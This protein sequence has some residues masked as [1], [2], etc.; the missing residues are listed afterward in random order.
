MQRPAGW[1]RSHHTTAHGP[2]CCP[3]AI[4]LRAL[5]ASTHATSPKCLPPKLG[6]PRPPR[7]PPCPHCSWPP[8]LV[9]HPLRRY[10][11]ET[12]HPW[13][14][15]FRLAGRCAIND[16]SGGDRVLDFKPP[17][18][19]RCL[20]RCAIAEEGQSGQPA[21][22]GVGANNGTD[23]SAW[24]V[25]ATLS[26]GPETGTCK[27]YDQYVQNDAKAF[28]WLQEVR[29]GGHLGPRARGAAHGGAAGAGGA[30]LR[31]LVTGG[32]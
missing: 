25:L 30:D 12:P 7:S 32:V 15:Y 21:F 10:P 11:S 2:G 9:P 22:V 1:C 8:P 4:C 18:Q 5:F 3:P 13:G 27:G 29:G 23:P 16:A 14:R 6:A 17:R 19:R 24:A 28:D 20:S 31:S 26:S